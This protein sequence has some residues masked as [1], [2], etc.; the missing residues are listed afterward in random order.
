MKTIGLV[1]GFLLIG[2][3]A[4]AQ[5][6]WI[7]TIINNQV[8]FG[9]GNRSGFYS[10]VPGGETAFEL[11]PNP[12]GSN[13][14]SEIT[15]YGTQ[16]QFGAPACPM[17]RTNYGAWPSGV[18]IDVESCNDN[19]D[20]HVPLFMGFEVKQ[21]DPADLMLRLYPK[22]SPLHGVWICRAEGDCKNLFNVLW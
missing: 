1:L 16:N 5:S 12:D 6:S 10:L 3:A 9:F 2:V 19:Q 15:L 22:E 21:G 18:I 17:V 13:N 8:W 11:R 4:H 7:D 14:H 20:E